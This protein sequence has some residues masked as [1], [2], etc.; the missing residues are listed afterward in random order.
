MMLATTFRKRW[1][2]SGGEWDGSEAMDI[3]LINL[4]SHV[5]QYAMQLARELYGEIKSDYKCINIFRFVF[6]KYGCLLLDGTIICKT[7]VDWCVHTHA[8]P[9]QYEHERQQLLP[10][11][12]DRVQITVTAWGISENETD[13]KL[14]RPGS[15]EA[16][17]VVVV[18]VDCLLLFEIADQHAPV[19][20]KVRFIS[21]AKR[22]V[23]FVL[24]CGR[25]SAQHSEG[26][27]FAYAA[28]FAFVKRCRRIRWP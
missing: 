28:S 15:R 10:W 21:V 20:E 16:P 9:R 13:L 3:G 18:F 24:C 25:V 11:L 7:V 17:L 2:S 14:G 12:Y 23:L 26:I 22:F 27:V 4:R 6:L 5:T 8:V 19:H 1:L